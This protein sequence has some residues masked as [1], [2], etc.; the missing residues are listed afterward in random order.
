MGV[1]D[2]ST[3][4]GRGGPP[5]LSGNIA[6]T[7]IPANTMDARQMHKPR[8]DR[9]NRGGPT[10]P[11]S[12]CSTDSLEF[13]IEFGV[14]EGNVRQA[15]P[16]GQVVYETN[17]TSHP[18]HPHHIGKRQDLLPPTWFA[19]KQ[20][21]VSLVKKLPFNVTDQRHRWWTYLCPLDSQGGQKKAG[22]PESMQLRQVPACDSTLNT[23]GLIRL[24]DR[25]GHE[26]TKTRH[27]PRRKSETRWCEEIRL[28]QTQSNS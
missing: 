15:H 22:F 16:R 4:T 8:R 26:T 27:W 23:I 7:D 17:V 1:F 21:R 24:P 18:A 25:S 5:T 9:C 20:Y 3:L 14:A 6:Y 19:H 28:G 2:S 10:G 11:V 12:A 13:G